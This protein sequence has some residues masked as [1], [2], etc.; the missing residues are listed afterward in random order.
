MEGNIGF[1]KHSGNVRFGHL[2]REK[3]IDITQVAETDHG[4]AAEFRAVCRKINLS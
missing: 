3:G 1:G 2:V 4:L